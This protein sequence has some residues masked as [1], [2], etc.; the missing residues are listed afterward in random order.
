MARELRV[1]RQKAGLHALLLA[2]RQRHQH[3]GHPWSDHGSQ[4]R[5]EADALHDADHLAE[6]L[7]GQQLVET[8]TVGEH[9]EL[10]GA[11]EG[12]EEV[13]GREVIDLQHQ[14]PR[15]GQRGLGRGRM[16]GDALVGQMHGAEQVRGRPV[17]VLDL[18][19]QGF[20][21]LGRGSDGQ[22]ALVRIG[23]LHL[24]EDVGAA[25]G[26]RRRLVA[27]QGRLAQQQRC[28]QRDETNAAHAVASTDVERV[29][30]CAPAP[31]Q[32]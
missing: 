12:L 9:H 27:G 20:G 5:R 6:F 23:A 2:G 8:S 14:A 32:S 31:A 4:L 11:G 17:A 25:A 30:E 28:S 19:Q 16:I 18:P 1:E 21:I 26:W 29:A 7:A 15:G 22:D 13:V 10:A 24:L 3:A